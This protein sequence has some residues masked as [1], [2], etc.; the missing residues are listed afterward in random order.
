MFNA[1]GLGFS[2]VLSFLLLPGEEQGQESSDCS[3]T[4]LA[5]EDLTPVHPLCFRITI[6]TL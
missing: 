5:V 6:T 4:S 3:N 1:L 2:F